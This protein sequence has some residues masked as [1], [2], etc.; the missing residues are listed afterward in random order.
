MQRH[1]ICVWR[2]GGR[3]GGG[4]RC[5]PWKSGDERRHREKDEGKERS[6]KGWVEKGR[7]REKTREVRKQQVAKYTPYRPSYSFSY[8]FLRLSH[9]HHHY[10]PPLLLTAPGALR[11]AQTLPIKMEEGQEGEEE[12]GEETL[13]KVGEPLVHTQPQQGGPDRPKSN[14][15]GKSINC[16]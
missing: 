16:R 5:I 10:L 8:F 2:E 4:L 3:D 1:G 11:R 15:D 12:G 7:Q 13:F 14:G 9:H 6:Q